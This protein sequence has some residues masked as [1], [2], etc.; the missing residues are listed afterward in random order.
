MPVTQQLIIMS[1]Q[2]PSG[3]PIANGTVTVRLQVDI[4][5]ATSGGPQVSAGR[6]VSVLLDDTGTGNFLLWP[7]DVTFPAGSV[8]FLKCYTSLGQPVW[9][10]ELTVA[11][12]ATNYLL[13]EGSGEFVFLL[14]DSSIDAIILET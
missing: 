10:G 2:D 14:E 11:Q 7:N 1:F 13:Q 8:Y 12:G 5:A 3:N 9:S 6:I 4:S